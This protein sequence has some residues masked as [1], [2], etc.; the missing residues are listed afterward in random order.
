MSVKPKSVRVL[1]VIP[2]GVEPVLSP[3]AVLAQTLPPAQQ[4]PGKGSISKSKVRAKDAS[5]VLKP[6]NDGEDSSVKVAVR[7]RPF[8]KR[9][10]LCDLQVV[11]CKCHGCWYYLVSQATP[12]LRKLVWYFTVC[13]DPTTF[14]GC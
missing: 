13:S 1:P 6:P 12:Y 5:S 11:I 2:A 10:L 9:Y 7:V 14:V 8:S 3:R 4:R